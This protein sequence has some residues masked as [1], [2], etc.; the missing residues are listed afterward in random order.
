MEAD[1][2]IGRLVVEAGGGLR[3]LLTSK[4]RLGADANKPFAP[5]RGAERPFYPCR[6][7]FDKAE[8]SVKG[9]LKVREAYEQVQKLVSAAEQRYPER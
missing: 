7:N 8:K 4:D 6:D 3:T 9:P 1:S 5:R 2:D